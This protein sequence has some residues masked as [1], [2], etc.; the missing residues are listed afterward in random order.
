MK[1]KYHDFKIDHLKS[2][3]STNS[4][5]IERIMK[6]L[7][8]EWLIADQQT[9]GRGRHSN[10]W[11]SPVGGLYATKVIKD[12]KINY[13]H[14]SQLSILS[15]VIASKAIANFININKIKLKWPNDILIGEDKLCGILIQT[16]THNDNFF[17]II[18]FGINI[19]RSI[20]SANDSFAYLED[21]DD[22]TSVNDL[23]E[24]LIVNFNKIINKW[25]YGNS[26]NEYRK[27][28]IESTSDIGKRI[29]LKEKYSNKSGYFE[30]IDIDGNLI[31]RI[32][33]DLIKIN[34][35]DVFL[36]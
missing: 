32:E 19:K 36:N 22:K 5:A 25:D 35:G 28:W 15:A 30:N 1:I 8:V 27:Y 20:Q 18:G 3:Q 26:F 23:L 10:K 11:V 31:L 29:I 16:L 6:G 7:D 34:T 9:N 12:N 33:N 13:S 17:I 24:K 4:L 14:I 2:V 21:F